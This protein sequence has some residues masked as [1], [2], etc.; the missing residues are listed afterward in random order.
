MI[1]DNSKVGVTVLGSGSNGN[2]IV[3]HTATDALLIDAG[4]SSRELRRRM[5]EAGIEES[6]IRA[7][8][9]SHEHGDHVRGLR[10]CA[11]QL[12]VPIYANRRTADAIRQRE[13]NLGQVHVFASGNPFRVGDYQL[14]PFSIPHDA[15]DPVGFIIRRQ[16][17]K[18]GLATDL[19][20]AS[21]LVCY[22]LKNCDLLVVE[23]NHDV[24]MLSRSERPWSLKQRIL[25]RHGHLS[26]EA[27]M[28][29][30]QKVLDKRTKY[31][32]LAHASQEC[33]RY[34]LVEE[35]I[36][37]CLATLKRDDITALVAKQDS[38]LPTIWV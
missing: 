7:I 5:R 11:K 4:F 19:G 23:S 10:I 29:L 2:A 38:W 37:D 12:D 24:E 18:I 28:E 20:H 35:S 33:N 21:H 8:V 16:D 32:V 3:I 34:E 27:S 14:E 1:L 25:S 36:R 15:N 26:N 9:V 13:K 30:L 6:L 31:L 17:R 22:Q